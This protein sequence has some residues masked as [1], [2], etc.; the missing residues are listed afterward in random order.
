M[1]DE[2]KL[3]MEARRVIE[4]Q[5]F[6]PF[7]T[8]A[9]GYWVV[10]FE[11]IAIFMCAFGQTIE[12]IRLPSVLFG[13]LSI[14]AAW[15]VVRYVWGKRPALI[16]A[17][18]LATFHFHI[19][20]S[21]NALNNIY[22]PMF[23][24]LVFGFAWIGWQT[25]RRRPWLMV[26]VALGL[27]QYFYVGARII[28]LQAAVLGL[29]WLITNPRR[30]KAQAINLIFAF[31]VFAAIMMPTVYFVQ[32]QPDNYW[33]RINQTNIYRSGWLAQEMQSLNV[34]EADVLW[35]QFKET[36]TVFIT[37][38]D[39]LFY[40]GQS[41]LTPLM[42]ILALIALL[43]QIVHLHAG[44]SFWLISSLVIVII[45]GGVLTT[46]PILGSQRFVGAAPLIYIA[47]AV[48]L[49]RII[50]LADRLWHQPHVATAAAIILIA[51][52]MFADA[53]YYF[54]SYI[55]N[56]YRASPDRDSTAIGY[57]LRDVE[58]RPDHTRWQVVC[59][60]Y[61]FDR[62]G[63]TTVQFLAPRLGQNIQIVEYQPLSTI[64]L[65]PPIIVIVPAYDKTDI[66]NAEQ[67]FP[68]AARQEHAGPLGDPLFVSFEMPAGN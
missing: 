13:T 67:R 59:V 1:G 25:G 47:I 20:F 2:T 33:T 7:T 42:S 4:G 54:G 36:L 26:A 10:S 64:D 14:L 17:A 53:H 40:R 50:A 61:P 19:H 5:L 52:L 43:Y 60:G 48:L 21:R 63:G 31:G 44:R 18:L 37:G 15:A 46:L 23:V 57:Y 68:S 11:V 32:Q 62:C 66:G 29:F 65:A 56:N 3:S 30:V 41:I 58:S 35:D 28:A 22:D 16:A 51:A 49:D 45:L 6:K 39:G 8:G 24:L 9:D 12:A 34:S 55:D 27:A 38:P